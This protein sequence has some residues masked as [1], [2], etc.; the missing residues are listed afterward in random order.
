[1]KKGRF[2]IVLGLL[3]LIAAAGLAGYNLNLEKQAQKS[4]N[5]ALEY[6]DS[7]LEELRAAQAAEL[8]NQNK[9]KSKKSSEGTGTDGTGGSYNYTGG[10]SNYWVYE[11]DPYSMIIEIPK[12]KLR[13]PVRAKYNYKKMELA[14]CVYSGSIYTDDLVICGH[15][16]KTH[17]KW[18]KKLKTGAK[19]YLT[20]NNGTSYKYKVIGH[21]TLGP[22]AYTDMTRSEADLTIFTC[23]WGGKTRLAIR[24]ERIRK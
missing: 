3:M 9:G 6:I 17:F 19:V 1:M 20:T 12:L 23:T 10:G 13:L 18:L 11:E 4:S 14:P 24:C 16:Y 7:Q 15:N 2:W 22:Y 5:A 8:E 21:E